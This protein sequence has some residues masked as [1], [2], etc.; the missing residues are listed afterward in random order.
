MRI[1]FFLLIAAAALASCSRSPDLGTAAG[2]GT[3]ASSVPEIPALRFPEGGEVQVVRSGEG[4]EILRNGISLPV[5][6]E[7]LLALG[8]RVRTDAAG[9]AE[10]RLGEA[11]AFLLLPGSEAEVRTARVS[12]GAVYVEIFVASGSALFDVRSLDSGE[13]FLVSAPGI[14]SGVRG[15]RFLVRAGAASTA[16]VLEGRVAV[17]PSGPV[18]GRLTEAARTDAAARAALRALVALAPAAGPGRE[19]RIDEP[20]LDR[21]EAAYTLLETALS[22]LPRVPLP[23]DFPEEPWFAASVPELPASDAG[24][25]DSLAR[26]R[27]AAGAVR[28]ALAVP[29]AA[30][31]ETLNGF[32]RFKDLRSGPFSRPGA[33]PAP[34]GRV[35]HP[36]ELGRT[37]LSTRP[38]AGSLVR[39]PDAGVFLAADESGFLV[40]FDADGKILWDLRTANRGDPRGYPV[41]LKGT[42]YYAG[43]AELAAVDGATGTLLAR[44]KSE[45]GSDPGTRPSPFSDSILLP[46]AGGID[47]LD[48]RTLE[49]RTAIPLAAGPGTLPVQRDSFA[50]VVD[51]QGTLLLVDPVSGAVQAS[52]PT[53]ARGYSAVSPRILEEKACFADPTG[54]VVM[55][56]LERMAVLWERRLGVSVVTDLE[57]AR[58]G[59]I[60]YGSGTLFG[61]RL[62]GETLMSPVPGVS[63]PPLLA[64]GTVYYGTE[65][66]EIVAA[67]A[68]PW[69]VRGTIPLGD[70]PSARPLLVGDTLYVGTRG[71]KLVRI[72]VTELPR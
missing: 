16:G 23:P 60:A 65:K 34:T 54:L 71:G 50:L 42:A 70:V 52:T 51:R 25:R 39:V 55:V 63:A 21:A 4:A 49:T 37:G 68:D 67:Q 17:L 20:A 41:S 35:V 47:V 33:P 1:E 48:P 43:D 19:I 56:D 3:P 24:S 10:I 58:E 12:P 5:E 15:T 11:A 64:R 66:G 28:P 9:S 29:A 31:P 69:R 8:D 7:T 59:V 22:G 44:R 2:P 46:T 45:P 18:L 6:P 30:G 62:D 72:D 26:A 13:S 32:E 36:A 40:A 57:L 53:G 38:L 27:E 61:Y 14:L